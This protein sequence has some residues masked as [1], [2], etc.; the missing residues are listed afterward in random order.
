M[1]LELLHNEFMMLTPFRTNRTAARLDVT[2][3]CC[4]CTFYSTCFTGVASG[5]LEGLTAESLAGRMINR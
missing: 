3:E 5:P 2:S 1:R 4:Y